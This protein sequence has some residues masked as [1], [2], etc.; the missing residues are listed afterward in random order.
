[1]LGALEAHDLLCTDLRDYRRRTDHDPG[2][3]VIGLELVAGAALAALGLH[4]HAGLGTSL[5][6]DVGQLVRHHRVA[7][8]GN[9][10]TEHDVLTV[11]K[12]P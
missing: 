6:G 12:R 1:V 10:W 11:G 2:R 9:A 7:G 8:V 3:R 5:L 4:R